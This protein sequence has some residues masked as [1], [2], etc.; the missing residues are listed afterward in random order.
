VLIPTDAKADHEGD[1][2]ECGTPRWVWVQGTLALCLVLLV[3]AMMTGLLG[4]H[5]EGHGSPVILQ[6]GPGGS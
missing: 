5:G 3:V 6:Q 1:M 2:D 4:R